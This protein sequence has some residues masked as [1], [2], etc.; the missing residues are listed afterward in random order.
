MD[1]VTTESVGQWFDTCHRAEVALIAAT[2]MANTL[3]AAYQQGHRHYHTLDHIGACLQLAENVALAAADR[4][5][6]EFALWFHDAVYDPRRDDNETRSA[7]MAEAWLGAQEFEHSTRV[8]D[9]IRMTAGHRLDG[10]QADDPA[11]QA[12]H[13]IDLAILGATAEQYDAYT[14]QIR[15]E[16]DFVDDSAFATGRRHVVET[17]LSADEIYVLAPLRAALEQ[18]ARTNLERELARL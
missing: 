8:G 15:V 2:D 3:V 11:L 7:G 6:A 18:Q 1:Q 14:R 10:A 13:D 16:Y 17:L 9:A 12:V 4:L 5:V